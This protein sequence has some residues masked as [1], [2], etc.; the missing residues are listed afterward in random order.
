M[1]E[2]TTLDDLEERPHAEVFETRRPRTE[3]REPDADER[4]P[5][6]THEGTN[7]VLHLLDG[8]LELTLD[9]ETYALESGELI[10]F[11]GDREVSP[12]AV[13]PSTAVVVFAPAES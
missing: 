10:R 9:E 2:R 7:V 5:R 13:E 4:V 8:R 1:P 11:S 12:Y 6:H 3:R